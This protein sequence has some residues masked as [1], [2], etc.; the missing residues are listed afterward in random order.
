M[1]N[2][3]RIKVAFFSFTFLFC[4]ANTF[5][6]DYR[7]A[8]DTQ[9]FSQSVNTGQNQ[10]LLI[11]DSSWGENKPE[12]GDEIAAYDSKGNLVSSVVYLGDH[13]GLALWGDDEHTELKEG[14]S[15]EEKF[16]LKWWKKSDNQLVSLEV[17]EFERGDDTYNKDDITVVLELRSDRILN[18]ELELFQNVPNPVA[19]QTEINFYLP[20]K[21]NVYLGVFNSLGQEVMVLA[22]KSYEAGSHKVD[23]I[24][25]NL[26]AGI[27][28]YKLISGE[29][30]LTK[31]MTLVK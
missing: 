30:K 1:T 8:M 21:N 25:P 7:K 19:S 31:Q 29:D 3:N 2:F 24:A 20:E 22:N 5:A 12:I 10:T 26:E 6:Q 4:S 9:R 15:K 13:T 11:L 23:M 28:F 14:L 18:Q 27:Y 16:H 17:S